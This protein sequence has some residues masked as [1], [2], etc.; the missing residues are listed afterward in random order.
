M[1]KVL[2]AFDGTNFSQGAFEFAKRLNEQEPILLVGSFLPQIEIS[3]S[4]SYAAG[5]MGV[6]MPLVED[7]NSAVI[8]NNVAQF[9]SLCGKHGIECRVHTFPYDLAIP[10]LRKESRFADLLVLG[11]ESFYH[12]LGF[13]KPNEYLRMMVQDAE[14]PVVVTPEQ[15]TFPQSVVLA[16]DGSDDAVYAIKNF[17]YLFPHLAQLDT[18]LVHATTKKHARMPDAEYITELVARHYPRLTVR[19]LEDTPRR[20]FGK[21][22]AD[23]PDP[24]VVSGAYGRSDISMMFRQSFAAEIISEHKLP[25]FIAHRA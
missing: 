4:W 6:V 15:F 9:E 23:M 1:K 25:L 3:S 14:C 24:I 21:W 2:L 17:A 12:Q 22:L 20:L 16:Y 18:T 7:F 5:S 19:E 11:G 10:E 8:E 13:E